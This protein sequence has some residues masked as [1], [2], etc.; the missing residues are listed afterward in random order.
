MLIDEHADAS[1]RAEQS[2]RAGESFLALK[3]FQ[4]VTRATF[5]D[6]SIDVGITEPL[7]NRA[8]LAAKR[9]RRELRVQF[10]IAKMADDEN[11]TAVLVNDALDN[12]RIFHR[13]DRENFVAAHRGELEAR[14]QIRAK[15]CEMFARQRTDFARIFFSLKCEREIR[16]NQLPVRR[17]EPI[18]ARAKKSAEQKNPSDR[19]PRTKLPHRAVK[20]KTGVIHQR[21]SALR[22]S[23]AAGFAIGTVAKTMRCG[24]SGQQ[25]P[26]AHFGRAQLIFSKTFRA[27][28][29]RREGSPGCR[30]GARHYKTGCRRRSRA[31]RSA[32]A[33]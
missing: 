2:H 11:K 4:P 10:P 31:G 33:R 8:A 20:Q 21:I 28:D 27:A 32:L 23:S 15:V 9:D 26:S 22:K 18:R 30:R 19:Q 5:A 14:E 25:I 13:H 3:S 16:E 1:A 17:R 12:F 29:A 7:I 6:I 24:K